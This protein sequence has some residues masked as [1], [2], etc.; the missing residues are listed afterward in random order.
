ME[1]RSSFRVQVDLLGE[2]QNFFNVSTIV[3]SLGPAAFVSDP[4]LTIN[5]LYPE[6]DDLDLNFPADAD[7]SHPLLFY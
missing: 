5:I 1:P 2:V 6:D 7:I 3:G 4:R